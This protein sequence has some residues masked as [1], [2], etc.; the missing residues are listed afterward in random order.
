VH[1]FVTIPLDKRG[2]P[3]SKDVGGLVTDLFG[4]G[5]PPWPGAYYFVRTWDRATGLEC[6]QLSLE[7]DVI[8]AGEAGERVH[9]AAAAHGLR[10]TVAEV[11]FEEIPSPLWNSGVGGTAFAAATK[12]LYRAVA[13]VLA[14]I[15][16]T[17]GGDTALTYLLVLR[18]MVAHTGATVLESEQRQLA[19]HDFAELLS[20]RLFSYRSHYEGAKHALAGDPASLDRRFASYYDTLGDHVQDFIR[21]CAASR[22]TAGDDPAQAWADVVRLHYGPVREQCRAGVI[23]HDG[24]GLDDVRDASRPPSD[25]HAAMSA[26]MSDFLQN[27]PDFLAYRI[28]TSLLYSCLYTIGFGLPERFLFCYLLARANEDVAGKETGELAQGLSA[29]VREL[30]NR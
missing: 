19:D 12:A 30:A 6:L 11:P 9:Q 29:V 21:D 10:P 16:P 14:Q 8:T 17:L 3:V 4:P 24:P 5:R 26:E 22:P 20:L 2:A 27:D 7:S 18:L 15:V 25:F 1:V 28:H 23:A 13:P